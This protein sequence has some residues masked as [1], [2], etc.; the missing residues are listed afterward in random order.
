M[1]TAALGGTRDT[2]RSFT[3]DAG[4]DVISF[5]GTKAGMAHGEA[6]VYLDPA[7][8]ERSR[9]IRKN[10]TQLPS[11]MRFIAAQFLALLADGLWIDLA[12]H[13]NAMATVLYDATRD[14]P[15][16][17]YDRAPA[18]NSVFPVL[19]A[20]AIEPLMAWCFF[21]PW[22]MARDQVRWMT[23]WD[24]TDADVAAFAGMSVSTFTR[25]FRRHTGSSFVRYLNR[26][27][28][29][30]EHPTLRGKP[31]TANLAGLWRYRVGDYRL[32]CDI[33]DGE[34]VV[35]VLLIGHRRE[36]YR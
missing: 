9:Y 10:V 27:L 17:E 24:T 3:V 23:A 19:P 1:T 13:A 34:L 31:L 29:E 11:K 28:V 15:G 30:A 16:V 5:G 2:L 14:I 12:A 6:V 21:W 7:L 4:V 32:I 20:A 36:V 33:Q 35:L 22:D 18:V 26:L 25:F 8:A